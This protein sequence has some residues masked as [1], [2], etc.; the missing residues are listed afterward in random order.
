MIATD[1]KLEKKFFLSYNEEKLME[2]EINKQEVHDWILKYHISKL[3][4]SESLKYTQLSNGISMQVLLFK[5]YSNQNMVRIFLIK[6]WLV[7]LVFGVCVYALYVWDLKYDSWYN[8]Y[9]QHF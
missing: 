4:L 6:M 9:T 5:Q 3:L 1:L 7:R 2:N 8:T